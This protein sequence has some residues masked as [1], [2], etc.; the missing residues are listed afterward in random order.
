MDR[1]CTRQD[2]RGLV[3]RSNA[4]TRWPRLA[5][6][7]QQPCRAV[8]VTVAGG[9][10]AGEQDHVHRGSVTRAECGHRA[11]ERASLRALSMSRI[12]YISISL[13]SVQVCS[14][15]TR[16]RRTQAHQGRASETIR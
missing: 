3:R 9:S 7:S 4:D 14:A 11:E 5:R 13:D 12:D 10:G 16:V 15:L 6:T 2:L 8:H 1:A